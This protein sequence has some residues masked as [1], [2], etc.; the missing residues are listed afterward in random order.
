[1]VDNVGASYLSTWIKD[2]KN[3]FVAT[4]SE[5]RAKVL[6]VDTFELSSNILIYPNPIS[7]IINIKVQNGLKVNKVK[8][9]SIL[10]KTIMEQ[11]KNRFNISRLSKGIYLIKIITDKGIVTRKVIKR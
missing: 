1:M 4:E 6:D 2:P 9:I 8:I 3:T 11:S 10:G 5:C 7:D